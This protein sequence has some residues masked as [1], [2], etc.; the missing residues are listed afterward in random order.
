ML[1]IRT[2]EG[3]YVTF[4]STGPTTVSIEIVRLLYLRGSQGGAAM[5]LTK[6][7]HYQFI[8]I[9]VNFITDI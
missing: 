5:A 8:L 4:G 9:S 3:N 1:T 7:V 2:S 6:L